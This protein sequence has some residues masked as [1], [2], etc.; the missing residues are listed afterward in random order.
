MA[1]ST[2]SADLRAYSDYGESREES[3]SQVQSK[4]DVDSSEGEFYTQSSANL[5]HLTSDKIS[6][7]KSIQN[8]LKNYEPPTD[9]MLYDMRKTQGTPKT[10]QQIKKSS[11]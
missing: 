2:N 8:V 4:S 6:T 7:E 5:K 11:N 3:K 9:P 10:Y 1:S